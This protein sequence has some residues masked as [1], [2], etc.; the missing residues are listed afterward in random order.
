MPFTVEDFQDLVQLLDERPEWRSELRR[1]VLSDEYLALPEQLAE[2]RRDMEQRF[3]EV[4]KQIA[5]LRRDM[6]AQRSMRSRR[7]RSLKLRGD[8]DVHFHRV[9]VTDRATQ[10]REPGAGATGNARTPISAGCS[11]RAGW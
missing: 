9:N 10:G 6:E 3:I 1:L 4:E 2:F 7:S 11:A 5:D 8:T